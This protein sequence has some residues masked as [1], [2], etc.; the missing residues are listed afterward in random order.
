MKLY[1]IYLYHD[2]CSIRG[3]MV[4]PSFLRFRVDE[5][6]RFEYATGGRT[7]FESGG[8]KTCLKKGYV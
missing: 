1:I 5:R 4:F 6:K 2:A 7:F 3:A 8:K